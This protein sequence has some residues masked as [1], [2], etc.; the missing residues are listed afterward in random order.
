[1]GHMEGIGLKLSVSERAQEIMEVKVCLKLNSGNWTK[2][3]L[4][5]G[6]P[7]HSHLGL[8]IQSRSAQ[9]KCN[10]YLI[11]ASGRLPPATGPVKHYSF[12]KALSATVTCSP[13][14]HTM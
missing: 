13:P 4:A 10:I 5:M 11:S 1:M 2:S 14:S 6:P 3:T 12:P 7:I 9:I 8:L